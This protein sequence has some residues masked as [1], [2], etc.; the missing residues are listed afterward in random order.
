M[1]LWGGLSVGLPMELFG[2]GEFVLTDSAEGTFEV[3][4]KFFKGCAGSNAC[5]GYTF[6][7]IVLPT[8]NVANVSLH[9][10]R[11]F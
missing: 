8:A 1:P 2:Y 6:G 3:I 5:F 4:G 11:A 7:G 9:D 10:F